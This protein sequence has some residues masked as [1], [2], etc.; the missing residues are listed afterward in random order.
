MNSMAA[1]FEYDH[2]TSMRMSG[3]SVNDCSVGLNP[4]LAEGKKSLRHNDFSLSV[5]C[6]FFS[7]KIELDLVYTV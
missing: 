5:G 1:V 3:F 2:N 6:Y 7:E 4:Q